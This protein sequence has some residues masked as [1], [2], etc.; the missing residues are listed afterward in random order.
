M[1]SN[2]LATLTRYAIPALVIVLDNGGYGTERP[3]SMVRSK[4]CSRWPTG[5]WP[6]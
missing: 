6:W 4:N 5:S 3:S 1:C 2:Q